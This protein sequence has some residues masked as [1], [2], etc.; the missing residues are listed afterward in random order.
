MVDGL[1]AGE[2]IRA[3]TDLRRLAGEVGF[4][5]R[6]RLSMMRLRERRGILPGAGDWVET[7]G[8]KEEE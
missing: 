3:I 7:L 4:L 5:D 8:W 6:L 1:S 2:W